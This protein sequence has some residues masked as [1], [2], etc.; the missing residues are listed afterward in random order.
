MAVEELIRETY[1]RWKELRD[2]AVTYC[3]EKQDFRMAR[4]LSECNL[5]T[6]SETFSE[7]VDLMFTPQGTEAILTYEFLTHELFKQFKAYEPENLGVFIDSNIIT[8]S[9]PKRTF[10]VGNTTAKIEMRGD[11][12]A[13]IVLMHGA[14]AEVE[15]HD[16][17]IAHIEKDAASGFSVKEFENGLV[18]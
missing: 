18:L 13:K 12:V 16:Y 10:L 14:H 15:V 2:K 4:K 1:E 8:L 17:A 7:L 11:A 6:G 5:F 9:D 3:I